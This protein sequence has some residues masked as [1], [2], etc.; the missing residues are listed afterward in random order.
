MTQIMKRLR[1]GIHA[2]TIARDT[3]VDPV[4]VGVAIE[5][6]TP[7]AATRKANPIFEPIERRKMHDDENVATFAFNPALESEHAILVVCMHDAK[8]LAA[9][10]GIA[11]AQVNK[12]ARETQ[13]IE[14]LLVAAIEPRP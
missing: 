9:Q 5:D 12:F 3:G 11:P 8:P 7:L 2:A 1:L 6:F 14:H 10:A 4:L 13:V